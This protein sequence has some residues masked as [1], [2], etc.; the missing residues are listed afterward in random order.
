MKHNIP[1]IKLAIAMDQEMFERTISKEDL[2]FL[3]TF[4][5]LVNQPPYPAKMTAAYMKQVLVDAQAA[6]TCWGTPAFDEEILSCAPDLRVILH[7]AGTPK[8]IVTDAVWKRGIRVATAAPIIAIDVA[9][10]ALGAM[11]YLGKRFRPFEKIMA[12]RQWDKPKT[13]VNAQKPHMTRLNY[14]TTVGVIS[15]S[16]VGVNMIRMLKPFG[17][18]TLL[19]DPF[20]T[21]DT[22]R[23]LG[24]ELVENLADLMRRSDIVTCHAPKLEA[25]DGLVSREMLALLHDGALFI[26][27]SRGSCVDEKALIDELKTGRISAYLDVFCNEPLEADSA[28][29]ELENVIVTPHISGGHTVNGGFERGNYIVNQLFTYSTRGY[30]KDETI[31]GMLR[32]M[33]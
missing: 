14:L 2:A 33:A 3:E 17:V 11:I 16:H 5:Q 10:T 12:Q 22:A 19:Y 1:K 23:Q 28:L 20:V 21:R 7:G 9:E 30:L 29:Y 32:T 18:K 4:A 27:T 15:A 24:V 25:T 13:L 31:P 8:A 26:N 6:F